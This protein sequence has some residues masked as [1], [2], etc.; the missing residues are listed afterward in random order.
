MPIPFHCHECDKPTVNKTGICDTCEAEIY[1]EGLRTIKLDEEIEK[2]YFEG[3]RVPKEKE[4][5]E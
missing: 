5:E 3:T 1:S 2:E 4:E